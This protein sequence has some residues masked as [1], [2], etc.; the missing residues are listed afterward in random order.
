MLT[1]DQYRLVRTLP[2][3]H[4]TAVSRF[5]SACEAAQLSVETARGLIAVE[6][7]SRAERQ[8][9]VLETVVPATDPEWL[10][11]ELPDGSKVRYR[12][13]GPAVE[14]ASL[15]EEDAARGP[16]GEAPA[17]APDPALT[18]TVACPVCGEVRTVTKRVPSEYVRKTC[19]DRCFRVELGRRGRKVRQ[20]SGPK[21]AE[22]ESEPPAPAAASTD[23]PRTL[24]LTCEICSAP[25]TQ[26]ILHPSDESRARK[27]CSPAC[28]KEAQRR[29]GRK[30]HQ[31]KQTAEDREDIEEA[32]R[33][34]KE[35][36]VEG[37][38]PLAEVK[39]EIDARDA[40][41]KGLSDHSGGVT[42]KVAPVAPTRQGIAIEPKTAPATGKGRF[43]TDELRHSRPQGQTGG[44][45]QVRPV[46][47][48]ANCPNCGLVSTSEVEGGKHRVCGHHV[49]LV[50]GRSADGKTIRYA[51]PGYASQMTE[52]GDSLEEMIG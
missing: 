7:E 41:L 17:E 6:C 34:L 21:A 43:W 29:G 15:P 42:E 8:E 35:A 38:I 25:Y 48:Q 14:I 39:A 4:L 18:V 11:E 52:R 45:T 23:Y 44:L 46:T 5:L 27:T 47:D 50:E 26:T 16:G 3:E 40:A 32:T 22:P 51:S 24:D 19:S 30:A 9:D 20:E 2:S 31:A 10:I 37:A 33:A 13:V 1:L 36:E 12:R 28:R 49:V